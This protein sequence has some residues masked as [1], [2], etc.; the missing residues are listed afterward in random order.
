MCCCCCC[1]VSNWLTDL[2]FDL[3]PIYI[4]FFN[5]SLHY[6]FPPSLHCSVM[7]PRAAVALL[8]RNSC[9]TARMTGSKVTAPHKHWPSVISMSPRVSG[10]RC[11]CHSVPQEGDLLPWL[12]D[13]QGDASDTDTRRRLPL[14]SAP[15]SSRQRMSAAACS[16]WTGTM[17]RWS[18]CVIRHINLDLETICEGCCCMSELLLEDMRPRRDTLCENVSSGRLGSF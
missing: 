3:R 4:Y 13:T 6:C 18:L 12:E 17:L 11:R 9:V 10:V 15:S 7:P 2:Q 5:S 14:T 8:G 16:C 1:C